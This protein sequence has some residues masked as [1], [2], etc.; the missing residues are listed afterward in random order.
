MKKIKAQNA[1]AA[2]D[3]NRRW[4]SPDLDMFRDTGPGSQNARGRSE[5]VNYEHEKNKK[6]AQLYH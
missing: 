5:A 1:L 4:G 2:L 6:H 3:C